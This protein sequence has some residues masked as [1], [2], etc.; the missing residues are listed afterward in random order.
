MPEH[1]VAQTSFDPGAQEPGTVTR[2]SHSHGTRQMTYL[3]QDELGFKY[4]WRN[5][6]GG[7]DNVMLIW[8]D[9]SG[10]KTRLEAGEVIQTYTPHDCRLT[11]GRCEYVFSYMHETLEDYQEKRIVVNALDGDVWTY[12]N[13]DKS[14]TPENLDREGTFTVDAFGLVID[15]GSLRRRADR[16]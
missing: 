4:E 14:E 1:G 5:K 13:Y 6:T 10:Q 15:S 7:Q 11:V 16:P 2:W 12:K 8:R 3:G 9:A